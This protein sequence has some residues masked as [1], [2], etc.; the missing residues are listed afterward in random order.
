M[1]SILNFHSI[2]IENAYILSQKLGIPIENDFNENSEGTFYVFGAHIK[3]VDLSLLQ[4]KK[5]VK[6]IIFQTEQIGSQFLDDKYYLKLLRD[7]T[8]IVLNWSEYLGA[9]LKRKYDIDSKGLFNY[10][11]IEQP[12]NN[13]RDIDFFFTGSPTPSRI[14]I[15]KKIK[16]LYPNA[17]CIFDFKWSFDTMEKLT[18]IL[19]RTK[20]VL[21]IPYY[22]DSV[23]ETH[24]I[25]KAL[26]CGCKVISYPSNDDDLNDEYSKY[27]YLGNIMKIVKNLDRL[28]KKAIYTPKFYLTLY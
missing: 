14:E 12:K 10:Q 26:T 1:T 17:L 18:N 20:Y 8:N 21:N 23:L 22:P 4:D 13:N 27:I 9:Q 15:C 24:R 19:M 25:N 6:Y 11:F 2:F 16:K 28:S 3:S 5:K 7:K